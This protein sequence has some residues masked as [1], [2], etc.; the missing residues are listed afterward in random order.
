V[1]TITEDAAITRARAVFR[2][3]RELYP[4]CGPAGKLRLTAAMATLDGTIRGHRDGSADADLIGHRAGQVVAVIENIMGSD[5][6][7][8]VR[9]GEGGEAA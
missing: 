5:A 7:A 2:R 3:A 8:W 1:S 4:S 6:A 9:D